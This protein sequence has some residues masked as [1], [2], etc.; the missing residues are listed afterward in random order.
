MSAAKFLILAA[1]LCA[2]SPAVGH[3]QSALEFAAHGMGTVHKDSLTP[4]QKRF[5]RRVMRTES[6]IAA[7]LDIRTPTQLLAVAER[8]IGS[9]RFTPYARAWCADALNAWLRQAGYRGTG[10]GRAISFARYGRASGLKVGAI[11]V[12]RHHVGIVV[13]R[14]KRGVVLLSGNH[15]RRV[16]IGIYAS[17]R[18]VAFREPT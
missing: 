18:I 4:R 14:S 6:R 5:A 12:M 3:C 2:A 15:S 9:R 7:P 11:A 10:D 16:G 17:H 1:A 13:G 8:Y